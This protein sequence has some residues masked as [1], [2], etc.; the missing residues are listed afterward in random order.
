MDKIILGRR[1]S[2]CRDPEAGAGGYVVAT[3]VRASWL[4]PG[5]WEQRLG[6]SIR[7]VPA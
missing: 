1:N 3:V 2:K 4:Q 6:K 7:K 5:I